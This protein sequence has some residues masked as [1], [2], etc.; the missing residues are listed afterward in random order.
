MASVAMACAVHIIREC[1]NGLSRSE[2]VAMACPKYVD[3][4]AP[5][6]RRPGQADNADTG[7]KDRDL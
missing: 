5:W 1:G 3:T 6:L 2:G 7:E 4:E